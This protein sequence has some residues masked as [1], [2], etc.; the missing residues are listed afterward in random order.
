MEGKIFKCCMLE[1]A[2]ARKLNFE[3]LF[4]SISKV[5]S[6]TMLNFPLEMIS[7]VAKTVYAEENGDAR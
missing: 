6:C 3:R 5:K 1:W 2:T 4:S 7:E